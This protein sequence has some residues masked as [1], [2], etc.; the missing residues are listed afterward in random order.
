MRRGRMSLTEVLADAGGASP[1]SA[2]SNEI[3]VMRT[4]VSGKPMV[5]MLDAAQPQAL[6]LAEQFPIEPRDV[7]FVNPTGPTMIGRFI[8]QFLPLI[9]T[10]T[11]AKSTPF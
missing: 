6:L 3:Y 2:A 8:G 5:Y 4:D 10:V 9:Q 11:T 1:F 7:I